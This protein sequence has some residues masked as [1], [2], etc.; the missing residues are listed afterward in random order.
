MDINN[1]Q[2]NNE[3]EDALLP[4]VISNPQLLDLPNELLEKVC[5][6]LD[7]ISLLNVKQTCRRMHA[8]AHQTFDTRKI[9]EIIFDRHV[10]EI[11]ISFRDN[12]VCILQ[13]AFGLLFK[14]L[15][16]LGDHFISA[17]LSDLTT[18]QESVIWDLMA[19]HCPNLQRLDLCGF[20]SFTS[21][22]LSNVTELNLMFCNFD[23]FPFSD[24]TAL[25]ILKLSQIH[26]EKTI[27]S[28]LKAKFPQLEVFKFCITFSNIDGLQL[29]VEQFMW[30]HQRLIEVE[31]HGWQQLR[32]WKFQQEGSLASLPALKKL[33]LP[34]EV[35][36]SSLIALMNNPEWLNSPLEKI[37]VS[38][39][40]LPDAKLWIC[41]AQLKHLKGVMLE[42]F[43]DDSMDD[44]LLVNGIKLM[45]ERSSCVR[46]ITIHTRIYSNFR[47]D[48][49]NEIA[50]LAQEKN[51]GI[52]IRFKG[53]FY[54]LYDDD[55][56]NS[57]LHIFDE[58]ERFDTEYIVSANFGNRA[59][60]ELN[61]NDM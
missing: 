44:P 16:S 49:Y 53:W 18:E 51:G 14:L 22:L 34:Y 43:C 33:V 40:T 11:G 21:P 58:I 19:D 30:R 8:I 61:I 4:V 35:D 6:E 1:S 24:L 26:Y 23:A 54:D 55:N 36:E 15:C 28:C 42:M 47:Q 38:L 52:L 25:R 59:V 39:E 46:E 50:Q 48:K 57:P 12:A 45:V 37:R 13:D 9:F 32:I 27:R 7:I 56:N 31:L 41:L 2:A 5:I 29:M 20:T 10:P 17:E 3:G 60:K